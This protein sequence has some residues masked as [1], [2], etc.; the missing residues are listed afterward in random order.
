M[1]AI[2][3][4]ALRDL[5]FTYRGAERPALDGINLV[6]APGESVTVLG[7]SGAGKSTL[8]CALNGLIPHFL[9]GEMSGEVRVFGA[10]TR[11]RTVSQLAEQVGLLFQE[12]ESQLFSTSVELEVAF[13]PENLQLPPDAIRRRVTA[14]LAAVGLDGLERREPSALSGGQKQRLA[15][16][17][18]LAL[19]PRILVMDEPTTD[20]DPAGRAGLFALARRLQQEQGMTVVTAE[21]DT[22]AALHADRVVVL[23]RGCLAADGPPADLLRRVD[24]LEQRGVAPP[25]M[26]QLF[27]RLGEPPYLELE[28]A[29]T[30]LREQGY[31]IDTAVITRLEAA[32]RARWPS[33]TRGWSAGVSSGRR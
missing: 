8:C 3:A 28:S 18:V 29:A 30:R 19:Q 10:S 20:L 2:P 12:F 17:A 1:A 15:L 26:A 6:V 23:D 13:G 33:S 14:T 25:A 21:H 7:A 31:G 24:W 5:R 9:R 11:E 32:E 27:T 16:A 4:L 22:E